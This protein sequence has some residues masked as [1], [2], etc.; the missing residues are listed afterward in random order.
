[1]NAL[2]RV[3]EVCKCLFCEC[4]RVIFV[5]VVLVPSLCISDH[6]IEFSYSLVH[7]LHFFF[8]STWNT[9]WLNNY[10]N[11]HKTDGLKSSLESMKSSVGKIERYIRN[12]QLNTMNKQAIV[13]KI[14]LLTA[15]LSVATPQI[16][17]IKRKEMIISIMR[18]WKLDPTGAVPKKDFLSTGKRAHNVALARV[19]PI[20]CATMYRGTC[21]KKK[22]TIIFYKPKISD[23][24]KIIFYKR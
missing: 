21:E 13:V 10:K 9:S 16:T 11:P 2:T 20:I 19:D 5:C 15:L 24:Y 17:N 3:C 18:A 22:L 4:E 6:L 8:Q 1:M 7:L 23:S 14:E 12:D